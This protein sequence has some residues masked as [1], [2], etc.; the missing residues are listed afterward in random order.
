MDEVVEPLMQNVACRRI[1]GGAAEKEGERER[2]RERDRGGGLLQLV[3]DVEA[4]VG[5]RIHPSIHPS[6]RIHPAGEGKS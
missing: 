1:K 6:I 3:R 4:D 2:E 5:L